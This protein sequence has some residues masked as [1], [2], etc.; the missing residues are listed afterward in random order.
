MSSSEGISVYSSARSD[1]K[2]IQYMCRNYTSIISIII[3]SVVMPY[4]CNAQ[5]IVVTRQV[6]IDAVKPPISMQPNSIIPL[7]DGG[8]LVAGAGPYQMAWAAKLDRDLNIV[9]QY[10]TG[11]REEL[12]RAK[13][14]IYYS[15]VEM[16]DGSIYLCGDMP[17]RMGTFQSGL[18]THLSP[19]GVKLDE[20][21]LAPND[22]VT[23]GEGH[24]SQCIAFNDG[25][26]ALGYYAHIIRVASRTEP[27]EDRHF[28]WLVF[29]GSDGKIKR[30]VS[31][32]TKFTYFSGVS[33]LIALKNN[34]L[35]FVG[36]SGLPRQTEILLLDENAAVVSRISMSGY[37]GLSQ[38]IEPGGEPMLFGY[39]SDVSPFSV[40]FISDNID[41]ITMRSASGR[42]KIGPYYAYN[43]KDGQLYMFGSCSGPG[44][45][46]VSCIEKIRPD[47]D[48][49]EHFEFPTSPIYDV[50]ILRAAA[51][52]NR[53]GEF[54]TA[55][56]ALDV[57]SDDVKPLGFVV[58]FIN[59]TSKK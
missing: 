3:A 38:P 13:Q 14:P 59:F 27:P 46:V 36:V 22:D 32:P 10:N 41:N 12:Q 23:R 25:V 39:S 5:N 18:I 50:G 51:P 28:Y 21:P 24:I 44:S 30:S 20:F 43:S 54:V 55:R 58:N 7:H 47:L 19:S 8:Y 37:F 35:V 34:R 11:V 15:G 2:W 45:D 6:T 40:A 9:W 56:P 4:E 16:K 31:I 57:S 49:M 48:V 53:A 17:R 26:V 42:L 29:I 33:P 52:T 1:R